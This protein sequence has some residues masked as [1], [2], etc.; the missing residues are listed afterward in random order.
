MLLLHKDG[1]TLTEERIA[2]LGSS[3][4]SQRTE[5][6]I[7]RCKDGEL[8]T[9]FALEKPKGSQVEEWDELES[10]PSNGLV[11][12]VVIWGGLE[13][14]RSELIVICYTGGYSYL[15]SGERVERKGNFK[16]GFRGFDATLV[17][18]DFDGIPEIVVDFDKPVQEVL[19]LVE[20]TYVKVGAYPSDHLHSPEIAAAISAARKGRKASPSD[21]K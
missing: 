11:P 5:L 12:G 7:F 21:H 2:I 16:V 4:V 6:R 8:Q 15:P 10:F 20:G 18:L 3:S 17:D 1:V 9:I 19:T 13:Y 14:S